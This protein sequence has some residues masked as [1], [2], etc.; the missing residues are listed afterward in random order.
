MDRTDLAIV[1]TP[2]GGGHRAAALAVAEEARARGLRVELLDL[3]EHAPAFLGQSYVTAHLTGQRALPNFYGAAYFAANRR[4][5]ALEPVRRGFDHVAFAGL[6]KRVVALAPRAVV[7]T[8]HLPLVVLGRARRTGA[9]A[10]PLLGVVT[11]YTAHACWAEPG[12]DSFA[13]GCD[14]AELE[15]V[16]HGVARD[17]I[18]RTGIP[19]RSA[20]EAVRRVRA[21]GR[22][23]ALRVLVTMGGFGA[24]PIR[25][26]VRSFAYLPF[27]E[28][29]VVCGNAPRMVRRVEREAARFGVRAK[30]IGFERDM[31]ARAAEA[32]VVVGKAGG[33][34]VSETMAAGRPMI[35]VGAVPGNE[36]LNE[37]VV[38]EGGAGWA[39]LPENVGPLAAWMRRADV[40]EAMGRRARMLVRAGAAARVVDHTTSLAWRAHRSAD[41]A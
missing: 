34:T 32:H 18:V 3:F 22:A 15:L 25:R 19:I 8:H 27:M 26:I 11:D 12:V 29:T 21:P 6:V 1:Y 20:F 36:K 24:G 23:E 9:L 16:E 35:V 2:V 33:L 14:L 39:A 13:V 17:R 7:A 30:V 5:G 10:A 28:L 40:V 41:A 31:A 38:V 4:E 37:R